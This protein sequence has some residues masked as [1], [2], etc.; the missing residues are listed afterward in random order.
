MN[1][2]TLLGLSLLTLSVSTGQAAMAAGEKGEGFIEG[3]SL[4]ILIEISTSTAI[5]VKASP[6]A[7]VMA[8]RKSGRMA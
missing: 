6:A 3:S 2:R 4:T 7:R 5:S 1:N 8:I